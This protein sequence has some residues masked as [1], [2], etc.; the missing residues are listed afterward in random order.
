MPRLVSKPPTYDQLYLAAA[1][2]AES[3]GAF[4]FFQNH[5]DG[6]IGLAANCN[7]AF[8]WGTADAEDVPWDGLEEALAYYRKCDKHGADL[9]AQM[10]RDG[11]AFQPPMEKL[12][13]ECGCRER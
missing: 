7:D 9:W 11:L 8:A 10:R 3:D 6:T 12:V 13:K 5:K 1:M 2:V 4:F